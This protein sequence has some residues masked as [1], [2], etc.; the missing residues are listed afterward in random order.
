MTRRASREA[1]VSLNGDE[2]R[3][4]GDGQMHMGAPPM[5]M[6]TSAT[7]RKRTPRMSGSMRDI[8]AQRKRRR[9]G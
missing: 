3:M 1:A 9:L 2:A 5:P 4:L 8:A 7:P 6:S